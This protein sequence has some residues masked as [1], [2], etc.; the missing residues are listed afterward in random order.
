MGVRRTRRHANGV[1][2]NESAAAHGSLDALGADRYGMGGV[3]TITDLRA[4]ANCTLR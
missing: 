3:G 4:G 1:E 2:S